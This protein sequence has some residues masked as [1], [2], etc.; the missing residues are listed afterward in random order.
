MHATW[1]DIPAEIVGSTCDGNAIHYDYRRLEIETTP[2]QPI[3]TEGHREVI[4]FAIG[5]FARKAK[6]LTLTSRTFIQTGYGFFTTASH[7]RS[8]SRSPNALP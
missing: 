2:D 1:F 8:L 6:T 5:H 4:A 7:I 3:R